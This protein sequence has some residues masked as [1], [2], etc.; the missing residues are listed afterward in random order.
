MEIAILIGT[1][2]EIIKLSPVVKACEQ[3]GKDFFIIHTNQHYTKE[4]D[5]IFLEELG[6][7]PAKYN[8]E[9]GSGSH[10]YQTG[11]MLERIETVLIKHKPNL[12]IL[13]GDTNTVLAGALAAAKLNIPVAHVEA[14][15]RSYDRTMPEEINRILTDHLSELLFAPT[16]IAEKN[17][18]NEGIDS[19]KIF[20]TGN[21]IVDA[22]ISHLSYA[23]KKSDIHS[24]LKIKQ[25]KYILLTMHREENVDN[26]EKL[27]DILEGLKKIIKI[28]NLPIIFPIHPR[29]EKMLERFKLKL[30]EGTIKISPLGYLDFL[31]LMADA[32]LILTDSG[33]IQEEACILKVGC[34]TLRENTERPETLDVGAN[35]LAGTDP[36]RIL[37]EALYMKKKEKEWENPFG[38]GK[39]A[40]RI[41]EIIYAR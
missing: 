3:M 18:K 40:K 31:V 10:G 36:D 1:R 12:I 22:V 13:E 4:M 29:T 28:L 41:V 24:R 34:V 30:P 2:P 17:L 15:L 21:T 23:R 16:D 7:P 32:Y 14:G 37:T 6:I 9:V 33:G 39:A 38:D 19:K 25:K 8:L 20:V 5:K 26:K 35:R 27:K 11:V